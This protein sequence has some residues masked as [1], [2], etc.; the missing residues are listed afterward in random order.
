MKNVAI[1]A[2]EEVQLC[3]CPFCSQLAAIAIQFDFPELYRQLAKHPKPELVLEK[4]LT[5]LLPCDE[6]GGMTVIY[7]PK[8]MEMQDED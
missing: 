7:S 5:I 1:V 4:L 6:C 2:L 3:I 8:M